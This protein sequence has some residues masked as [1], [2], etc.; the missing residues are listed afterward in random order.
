MHLN[1]HLDVDLVA[2]EQ[3]DDLTL[4]LELTA[5]ATADDAKRPPAA[6]Q[7]VLDRSGSMDGERLA[8]AQAALIALVDRLDPGDAF[9]L[10]AFDD[11]V[12]VPVPAGPLTSKPAVKAAIAQLYARG[13]TNLSAGLLRGLQEARRVATASG[14]TLL[15]ISDGHAN[16]GVVD[17]AQLE[18]VAHRADI[19]V[20]T[21]G[22][23]LGYDE[24]LLS[25]VARGG[26]GNHVFAPDVDT[27][28]AAVAGEVEGLL[29]TTVQ[30]A[31]L[32][33][34]PTHAVASV[35]VFNDLPAQPVQDGV[36]VELGDLYAGET[37]KVLLGLSV[38]AMPALGLAQVA[39][40]E[41]RA[42]A[43][44]EMVER[45]VTLPVHVNVVPGDQA[46]G[47]I[48]NPTVTHEKLYLATQEAKRQAGEAL[49]RGDHDAALLSYDLADQALA[50][51]PVTDEAAGERAVL[52]AL[53]DE[54][55]AGE[56]ASAA[57]RSA[58]E[59]HL[60]SRKRGRRM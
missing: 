31:S 2:V 26:R 38:P 43:L 40:L 15:L 14:A 49:A 36:M 37:R 5:P 13:S 16:A 9:G 29:D 39:T 55:R 10:V 17:P 21:V 7:V 35:T 34:R 59:H 47:R 1:A 33:I 27:A 20:S 56:T 24:A 6:V 41:V 54:V 3:A 58:M 23:G 53:M 46:A 51:G 12:E 42:V 32:T 45:V 44:P 57:K 30:A 48:P 25:A 52:A 11:E 22:I 19:T 28:A 60:K 50:G 4:L 18:G 8:A